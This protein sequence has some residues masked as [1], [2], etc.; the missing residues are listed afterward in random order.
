MDDYARGVDAV[1]K[2]TPLRKKTLLIKKTPLTTKNAVTF[3]KDASAPPDLPRA[4]RPRGLTD[5]R[6]DNAGSYFREPRLT[7]W[8]IKKNYSKYH[9]K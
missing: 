3:N 8:Q 6:A 1:K 2:K 9:T 5:V 7:I 4:G